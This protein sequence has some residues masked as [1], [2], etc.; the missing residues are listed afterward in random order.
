MQVIAIT[1]NA[2]LTLKSPTDNTKMNLLVKQ[3]TTG[4]TYSIATCKW[5]GGSAIAY[6]SSASAIDE[7]SVMYDGLNFYC[8]G[9]AAFQ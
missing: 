1:S 3:D 8:M 2:T 7:I 6:S 4:H 9:G 5:A